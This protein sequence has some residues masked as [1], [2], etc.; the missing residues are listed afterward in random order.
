MLILNT[1]HCLYADDTVLYLLGDNIYDV[2]AKLQEDLDKYSGWCIQNC[3]TLNVKKT[4]Y[5]IF[6]TRQRTKSINDFD[7]KLNDTLLHKEPFYK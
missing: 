5:V 6:G 1:K 2:V 3:L 7:L 4:K